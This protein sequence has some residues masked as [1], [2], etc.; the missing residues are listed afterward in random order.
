VT[1]AGL[2]LLAI[3]LLGRGAL[4]GL[5]AARM[6]AHA[7]R[8]GSGL[9]LI[10]AAVL[11]TTAIPTE[12]A[13]AAPGLTS[14]LQKVERSS[15]AAKRI[16][17]LTHART[18]F[19]APV[20]NAS[21]APLKDYGPAPQFAGIGSWLNTG[22]RP[23]SMAGLRGKVVLID[24]WTY[25]CVNCI[26]TL[27]YLRSW[28]ARYRGKGLVIVG[29]HT[30]EFAFEHVVSNV[31]EAIRKE[32]IR[33]PVAIDNEYATWR[34]FGNQYWPAHYL[35]D[36]RGHVR[37]VHFGEGQYAETERAIQ[38]LLGEPAA[39]SLVSNHV[40][41]VTPGTD[42]GTPEI[43]LGSARGV[44]AQKVVRNVMH[45]YVAPPATNANEVTLQGNWKVGTQYLT[46]G[47]GASIQLAYTARRA[48]LVFGAAARGKAET[49]HVKVTGAPARAVKVD[50]DDLY[51]VAA[52]PGPALLRRLVVHVPRGVR[53]YSFTFG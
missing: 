52:I 45:G 5:R 38:E 28:D 40:K 49:V 3:A 9:V 43:Y 36:R 53:A 41:A 51:N 27:P 13:T 16:A 42:V 31:R 14:S 47:L 17:E 6:H 15:D 11:F 4:T 22:G 12:L 25:S 19:S 23:L 46:A 26:R 29:V 48:Y 35:I 10:G 7:V 1:G 21:A 24:F 30:P 20:A 32:G 2:P 37:D 44:Y 34:A 8:R 18:T 39:S 33:Y 50:H